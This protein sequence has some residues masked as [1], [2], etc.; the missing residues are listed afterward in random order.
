MRF[1]VR[2]IANVTFRPLAALDIGKQH[3]SAWQPC[4]Y[5][6]TATASNMEVATTTVYAQGGRGNARLIAWEGE[7]T[8]TFTVT[9]AL[10]SPISFSMLS[11]AGVIDEDAGEKIVHLTVDG[12]I[13]SAGTKIIVKKEDVNGYTL[14]ASNPGTGETDQSGKGLNVYGMVLDA[15]GQ[16]VDYLGELEIVQPTSKQDDTKDWEISLN[17]TSTKYKDYTCRIDCYAKVA[18]PVTTLTIDAE[19]FGGTFYIE[20]ETL[21]RD[22]ATGH[23]FPAT[24]I[25]PKGKIAG[26]FTFNMAAT[27]DPSTFDFQIDC[28]VGRVR[29]LPQSTK[30]LYAIDIV[31]NISEGS[32]VETATVDPVGGTG[33]A[34]ITGET[35][36]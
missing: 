2:E 30:V 31:D 11:G 19:N 9:D 22:E 28:T 7:K 21:F 4:L 27:G 35:G 8:A 17:G 33:S 13:N 16:I 26:N 6:D 36:E 32:H 34:F 25:I 10:L 23:D 20:A 5:I 29:T 3:F 18:A 14:V 15:N 24:F 12:M 1:G